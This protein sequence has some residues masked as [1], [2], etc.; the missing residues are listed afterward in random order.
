MALQDGAWLP[1]TIAETPPTLYATELVDGEWWLI[2]M[3]GPDLVRVAVDG[4]MSRVNV[5]D[6]F[7]P[8]GRS[9]AHVGDLLLGVDGTSSGVWGYT[10][11]ISS[12]V[13]TSLY[14][15]TPG[16]SSV[17]YGSGALGPDGKVYFPALKANSGATAMQTLVYDVAGGTWS[18][19][20]LTGLTPVFGYGLGV[21]GGDGLMY[22]LPGQKTTG[23]GVSWSGTKIAVF[24]FGTMTATIHDLPQRGWG[25]GLESTFMWAM[26]APD[27]VYA[28]G[29]SD[30]VYKVTAAGAVRIATAD[31]WSEYYANGDELTAIADLEGTAAYGPDGLLY[32]VGYTYRSSGNYTPVVMWIDPADDSVHFQEFADMTGRPFTPVNTFIVG[33]SVRAFSQE[34]DFAPLFSAAITPEGVQFSVGATAVGLSIG[35]VPVSVSLG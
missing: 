11:D 17:E 21:M 30:G 28:M 25:T 3:S 14:V 5:P 19:V 7:Y 8:F 6:G 10:Y 13:S 26:P 24:D 31:R 23:G 1:Q 15:E 12:G 22:F 27:G 35:A 29:S 2:Y 34:F 18:L 9:T 16:A 33:D 20:A 32:S 4:T